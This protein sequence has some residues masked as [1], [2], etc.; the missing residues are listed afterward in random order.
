MNTL[1]TGVALV[2]SGLSSR[3]LSQIARP[4]RAIPLDTRPRLPERMRFWNGDARGHW[5]GTT[6]VID[7]TNFSAKTPFRPAREIPVTGEHVH[8]T[9]RLTPVDA[10]TLHYEVTVDDPIT[11]TAPW[12]AVTTW[13]RSADQLFEYACH[14]ANY[15]LTGILRGARAEEAAAQNLPR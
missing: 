5:N 1:V 7:T 2:L 4:A 6:L 14:E 12:T 11:W 9:E 3:L 15:A 8:L 10:N 13:K